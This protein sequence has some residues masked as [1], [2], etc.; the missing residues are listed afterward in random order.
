VETISEP[1]TIELRGDGAVYEAGTLVNWLRANADV[2][3]HAVVTEVGRASPGP[4]GPATMGD[5]IQVVQLIV[6][7]VFRTAGL[8]AAI[9]SWRR[10]YRPGAVPRMRRGERDVA[11]PPPDADQDAIDDAARRLDGTD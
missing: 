2:G 3:A 7:S 9:A 6:D 10:A 5:G 8:V 11:A 4:D 1:I